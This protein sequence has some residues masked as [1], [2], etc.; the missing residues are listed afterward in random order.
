VFS[1]VYASLHFSAE[2]KHTTCLVHSEQK[3]RKIARCLRTMQI[4]RAP[5][6]ELTKLA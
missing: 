2:M 5:K 3:D 6:K 4:A 1:F